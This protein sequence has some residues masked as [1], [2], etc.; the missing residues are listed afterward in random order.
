MITTTGGG[1][2]GGSSKITFDSEFDIAPNVSDLQVRW[3][4][5]EAGTIQAIYVWADDTVPTSAGTYTI[6]AA[7]GGSSIFSGFDLKSVTLATQTSVGTLTNATLAS[8]A[9]VEFTIA[10]NNADLAGAGM[11]LQI[12]FLAA[13]ST[14]TPAVKAT[15]I[16]DKGVPTAPNAPINVRFTIPSAST[17]VSLGV[18]A[19]DIAFSSA[20]GT[21]TVAV[22]KDPHGTNKNLLSAATQDLDGTL[23]AGTKLDLTLTGTTADLS[24]AA[25]K[26]IQ[27]SFVSNN[28]DL[29]GEGLRCMLVYREV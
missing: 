27:F 10:S 29:I 17:I 26:T 19:D 14:A 16:Q 4:A 6:S 24:V 20:A 13:T 21:F 22:A 28:A 1:G 5:P 12:V 7:S 2:G 11:R 25:G 8:G 23:T 3:N 18:I 15:Q 9:E